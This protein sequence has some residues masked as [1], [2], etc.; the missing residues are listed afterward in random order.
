FS[1]VRLGDRAEVAHRYTR[2]EASQGEER[3]HGFFY[4][5][6]GVD[7]GLLGLPIRGA[8]PPG[9]EH[10]VHGSAAV[11]FLRNQAFRLTELGEL[12]AGEVSPADGCR[13]SC[14]DWY[15]NARPLFLRGRI[16]ALLGYEIVEG[17]ESD[18]RIREVR[19]VS[20]APRTVEPAGR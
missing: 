20:F 18:G 5:P 15:G 19:R 16:F 4:R 10:L 14:V 3:T 8:A 7:A 1:G 13:A 17:A 12:A 2:P 11:L 9:Y 6:E